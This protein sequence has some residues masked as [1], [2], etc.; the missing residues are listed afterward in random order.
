MALVVQQQGGSGA[1]RALRADARRNVVRVLEAA[2][3]VFATEGISVPIDVVAAR[4]GVGI[5]TVYRHFPTKEALLE[6]VV[7]ARLESLTE[8]AKQ[9]STADDSAAALFTFVSEMAEQAAAKKDLI[10]QLAGA[11]M[12]G[13]RLHQVKDELGRAFDVLLQRAQETGDVR[14]D[15]TSPDITALLMGACLAA[16]QRE[17]RDATCRLLVTVLCDGLRSKPRAT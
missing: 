8:R 11:H 7:I 1:S 9:L 5:G 6:A 10:D 13:E 3:Q 2:E 14:D 4:A 17:E 15:V 12:N 16:D